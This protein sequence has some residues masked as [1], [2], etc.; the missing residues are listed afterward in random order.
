MKQI[1]EKQRYT[2]L[3]MKKHGH[4]IIDM[5]NAIIV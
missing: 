2:I 1:T 5:S 4:K 3:V